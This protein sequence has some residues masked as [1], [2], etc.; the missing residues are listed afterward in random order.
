MSSPLQGDAAVRASTEELAYLLLDL[1]REV[2]SSLDLQ[3]VLDKSF[4]ALRKLVDFNGGAIQLIDNGALVAAA[5]DPPMS[6]EAKL[7]R[8]PVGQGISGSIAATGQPIYIPDIWDD[9]RIHPEGKSRGVST[10]VRSYFGVPLIL[11]GAPIGVLQVDSED[12]DAFDGAIR[13]RIL[14]F[15]PTIAAAVQNA[16]MFDNERRTLERLVEAERMQRDFL[17]VVSHEL[18]TPLTSVAGFGHTLANHAEELDAAT[19]SEFGDRIWR[20]GRRLS[21]TMSDLLDLSQIEHGGLRVYPLNVEVANIVKECVHEQSDENHEMVLDIEDDLPGAHVDPDRLRH[22]LG[23]LISNARKFS[24]PGTRIHI[25]AY[26]EDGAAVIAVVDQGRGVVSGLHE[27]IFD[28][29]FQVEPAQTRS[30]DGLGIGLFMVRTL[31][32]L[33]NVTVD[34]D[35][36]PGKGSIFT[37]RLPRATA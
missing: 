15:V 33:M 19:V 11:H 32:A 35:S 37:I 16:M 26:G 17:A 12:V 13:A 25:R 34:V 18:R 20:A 3:E 23:N 22:V 27:R 8:I 1:S 31:C 7:V 6:E 14:A 29:F 4:V 30:V 5:T 21:R 36:E 28:R 9:V 2:T 24:A 10:G